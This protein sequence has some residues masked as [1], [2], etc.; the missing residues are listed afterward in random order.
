MCYWRSGEGKSSFINCIAEE[1]IALE[2]KGEN[3]TKYFNKYRILKKIDEEKFGLL[4]IYD[5]P[6]FTFDGNAL[7]NIKNSIDEKFVLFNNR[8]DY[9]H[10]FLYFLYNAHGRTLDKKEIELIN[11]INNKLHEYNQNSLILFV[12]NHTEKEGEENKF[13]NELFSTLNLHFNNKFHKNDIIYINLKKNIIGIDK[14]FKELYNFFKL[15][16]IDIIPDIDKPEN[17]RRQRELINKSIFF[18]Y[19][20]KEEIM[21]ERYRNICEDLIE[22]YSSKVKKEAKE[23]RKEEIIKLREEL[24]K[25]IE[26]TLNSSV[27][28]ENLELKDSEKI[29][30][31]YYKIPLLGKWLE[32]N[33]LTEESPRI[34]KEIGD[35]FI[36]CHIENMRRTSSNAFCLSASK[37]YNNSVDLLKIIYELFQKDYIEFTTEISNN[38]FIIKFSTDFVDPKIRVYEVKKDEEF[39][40]FQ[41]E[42]KKEE[43]IKK[44]INHK[45][46]ITKFELKDYLRER[47]EKNNNNGQCDILVYFKLK[48]LDYTED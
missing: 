3:V 30:R 25:K 48:E 12:I 6:G 44:T 42:I 17:D 40:F 35:N 8:H 32:G 31:W 15:N 11:H 10:S 21:I 45:E 46:K 38:K 43:E 41:I 14:L 39:Y 19:I 37:D 22:L 2:G 16:K 20:Q 33:Y 23:L 1:K 27:Y 18:K 26:E 4:N 13:K 24:L 7:I 28:F 34:T 47:V 36:S 9:I 5:C 29:K